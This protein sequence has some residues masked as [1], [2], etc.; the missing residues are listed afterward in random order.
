MANNFTLIINAVDF[1]AYI[2]QET[3]ITETMRKVIGQ[4]QADAVDGTTIPDQIK[5]KWDP[6]FLLRPLPQD[7]MATLIA[8]MEEETVELEYTTVKLGNAI[9]RQITAIPVSMSV[10]F[11]T[12]YNGTRIYEPTP[13]SCEE[14]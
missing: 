8:I 5:V 6:A 7:M 3:D 9:L 14:V 4:A 11:A 12:M 1:S 13:I 10:K 2:Q